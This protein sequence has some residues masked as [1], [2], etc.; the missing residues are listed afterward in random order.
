MHFYY[1]K[2]ENLFQH[3]F[4]KSLKNTKAYKDFFFHI[5]SVHVASLP[6]SL[7]NGRF[8]FFKLEKKKNIYE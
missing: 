5:K 4:E 8:Y 2:W 3:K 7:E 6:A 1:Y